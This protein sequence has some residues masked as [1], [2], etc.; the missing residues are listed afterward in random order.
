MVCGWRRLGGTAVCCTGTVPSNSTEPSD[1]KV[2]IPALDQVL[3]DL[4]G[5][6]WPVT[7]AD[8]ATL[9]AAARLVEVE[10]DNPPIS[11][12]L[13]VREASGLRLLWDSED[14]WVVSVSANLLAGG[15]DEGPAVDAAFELLSETLRVRWGTPRAADPTPD[16]EIEGAQLWVWAAGPIDIMVDHGAAGEFRYLSVELSGTRTSCGPRE[17]AVSGDDG[18]DNLTVAS[19]SEDGQAVAGVSGLRAPTPTA[20]ADL[21]AAVAGA[22]WPWSTAALA[23]WLDDAGLEATSADPLDVNA[24]MPSASIGGDLQ[25]RSDRGIT[26]RWVAESGQVT[27][28]LLT[29][30]DARAVAASLLEEWFVAA[31]EAVRAQWDMPWPA[32]PGCQVAWRLAE[33]WVVLGRGPGPSGE[34]VTALFGPVDGPQPLGPADVTLLVERLCDRPWPVDIDTRTDLFAGL[35]ITEVATFGQPPTMGMVRTA[36]G[37]DGTWGSEDGEFGAV[38]AVPAR[39]PVALLPVVTEFYRACVDDV[40]ASLGDPTFEDEAVT[41]WAAEETFVRL[42][43]AAAEEEVLLDVAVYPPGT[44]YPGE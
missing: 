32:G 30:A 7:V 10:A 40:T 31:C 19:P 18:V 38:S 17:G 1:P 41:Q 39:L 20:V 5:A 24:D 2:L 14:G 6:G 4:V 25:V 36:H 16:D 28:L 37:W 44:T 23:D 12:E 11:G 29:L 33:G 8:R 43:V 34:I 3:A 15:P 42:A 9:F 27:A 35:G 13:R 21:L 22:G 26:G